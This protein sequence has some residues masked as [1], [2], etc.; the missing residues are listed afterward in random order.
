MVNKSIFITSG[1]PRGIGAEVSVKALQTLSNEIQDVNIFL[2]IP[3]SEETLVLDALPNSIISK[4]IASEISSDHSGGLFLV[5]RTDNSA[6]WVNECIDLCLENKNCALVT[7]PLSK[8]TS[9]SSEL[10]VLGH[11]D[12]FRKRFPENDIFMGF[13]GGHFNILLLTD[14]IPV[15]EVTSRL[16]EDLIY[17]GLQAAAALREQLSMALKKKPLA[18]LGLNPHAGEEG[19]IG[20]DEVRFSNVVSACPVD[21]FG[22]LVP[23]AAFLPSNIDKYSVI[24]C[25]YHDQGLIPFKMAH[26]QDDGLQVTLGLPFLRTSVDHGTAENIYGQNMA[27]PKSMIS[28]INFTLNSSFR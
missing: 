13:V 14:H 16:S 19:L 8:R 1:D 17:K 4:N 20:Q 26:G 7:G 21:V 15:S 3:K 23:D 27:N 12:L 25:A 6:L 11:T 22:P 10:E 28:A 5:S 18:L 9:M 2:F 24:I